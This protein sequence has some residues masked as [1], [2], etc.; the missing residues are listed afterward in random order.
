MLAGGGF[1]SGWLGIDVRGWC[2]WEFSCL[3]GVRLIGCEAVGRGV[4]LVWLVRVEGT[5]SVQDLVCD[6]SRGVS[7]EVGFVGGGGG[8]WHCCWLVRWLC[9]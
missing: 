5:L 4:C 9:G 6:S 1:S 2:W 3:L 7:V 8:V